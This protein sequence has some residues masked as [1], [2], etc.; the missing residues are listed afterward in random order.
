MK[1]KLFE[2]TETY[3]SLILR[4]AK[5]HYEPYLDWRRDFWLE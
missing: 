1:F 3:P 5:H 2:S 4:N